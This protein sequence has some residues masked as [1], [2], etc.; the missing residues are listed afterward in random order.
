MLASDQDPRRSADARVLEALA[1]S[2]LLSVLALQR[3]WAAREVSVRLQQLAAGAFALDLPPDW[4]LTPGRTRRCA[5]T[6]RATVGSG[7]SCC[8]SSA[9]GGARSHG[10][11]ARIASS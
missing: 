6:R 11:G 1:A 10:G 5:S 3:L 8:R 2:A 7:W 9:T 4:S